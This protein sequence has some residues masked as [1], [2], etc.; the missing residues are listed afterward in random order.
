MG[1]RFLSIVVLLFMLAG[2]N[3]AKAGEIDEF[4]GLMAIAWAH[5]RD[6]LYQSLPDQSDAKAT[7]SALL[8]FNAAWKILRDRW[9]AGPPP[10]YSEDPDF[11]AE[12]A[13]IAEIGNQALAL[14]RKKQITETQ[15]ALQQIPSLLAEM[16]RKN[17][18]EI[19]T[20]Q[21]DAFRELLAEINDA[22][23]DQ[24]E[25]TPPQ[26]VDMIKMIGALSYLR[27]RLEK[28]A[29]QHLTEDDYFLEKTNEIDKHLQELTLAVLAGQ[30]TPILRALRDL[31][32]SFQR[33]YLLYG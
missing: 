8:A 9:K 18:I 33:F 21:A 5:C 15:A 11:Q 2:P 6:A 16:R 3:T 28:R 10:H 27:E 26:V 30:R 12:L 1:K 31:R 32:Q 14:A 29:P 24:F 19:F 20:D 4:N 7:E 22:S 17:K 23:F 13:L 25:L